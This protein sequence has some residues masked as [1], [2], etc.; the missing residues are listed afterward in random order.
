VAQEPKGL[1]PVRW[2][3]PPEAARA[4]GHPKLVALLVGEDYSRASSPPQLGELGE[5]PGVWQDLARMQ[6]RLQQL[7]FGKVMVLASHQQPGSRRAV[8]VASR[9]GADQWE[10]AGSVEVV[11]AGPASRAGMVKAADELKVHLNA[12]RT[13]GDAQGGEVPPVF[14]F[15]YSG[16]GFVDSKGVHRLPLADNPAGEPTGD[17]LRLV[18]DTVGADDD[19]RGSAGG[20]SA[21]V[22]LDCCQA[23]QAFGSGN[24]ASPVQGGLLEAAIMDAIRASRRGR[25]FVG[26]SLGDESAKEGPAGGHFTAALCTSLNPAHLGQGRQTM[27]TLSLNHLVLSVDQL[28]LEQRAQAVSRFPAAADL[29]WENW[30]LFS[31]PLYEGPSERQRLIVNTLPPAVEMEVHGWDG[32]AFRD[33]GLFPIPFVQDAAS[34]QPA[35]LVYWVPTTWQGKT[36]RLKAKPVKAAD[37]LGYDESAEVQLPLISD[38]NGTPPIAALALREVVYTRGIPAEDAQF[39]RAQAVYQQARREESPLEQYRQRLTAQA[40]LAGSTHAFAEPVRQQ[41]QTEIDELRPGAGKERLEALIRLAEAPASDQRYRQAYDALASLGGNTAELQ[42]FGLGPG[43]VNA[44]LEAARAMLLAEWQAWASTRR[45]EEAEQRLRSGEAFL[46]SGQPWHS[47]RQA[48]EAE[49]LVGPDERVRG[50]SGRSVQA[51]VQAFFPGQV[52]L[53]VLVSNSAYGILEDL[54]QGTGVFVDELR[55]ALRQR[56]ALDPQ[57]L[58]GRLDQDRLRFRGAHVEWFPPPAMGAHDPPVPPEPGPRRPTPL[59][60]VPA[61]TDTTVGEMVYVNEGE[62]AMGAANGESDAIP[63]HRALLGAFGI[64]KHEVTAEQY[65]ACV[66]AGACSAPSTGTNCSWGKADRGHHPINCVDWS[67]AQAYCAWAGKRLPTEAEWEKAARG[68]D[69]RRYPWGWDTVRK[70]ANTGADSCCAGDASDGYLSTAPVGGFAAGASRYGAMDMAGNVRE[71]VADWYGADYYRHSPD[72]NPQGPAAG[73]ARVVR[74]GSWLDPPT[75]QE[76]SNRA[77]Y[78]PDLRRHDLG[79]RCAK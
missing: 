26:A 76:C 36:L 48:F 7:G 25:F 78:V 37:R 23:G 6:R 59:H 47:W 50:L 17:L 40:L 51:A 42:E 5:L 21:L 22:L 34:T 31:N 24:K 16:H 74:G 54:V 67:Q 66:Q 56:F 2:F 44:S 43:V 27:R 28:L 62:Y 46:A 58:S 35:R 65:R 32:A 14:V 3:L 10:T 68:T 69:E 53:E 72:A 75:A 63:V 29:Q 4:Q 79:F 11:C 71:W 38:A 60:Q 70:N 57:Q 15:Y 73:T 13:S 19:T 52:T 33:L 1:V 77:K 49:T 9:P 8:Q 45:Q 18:L 61:V 41:L 12:H 20:G 64:D 30:V 39:Q 55:Q